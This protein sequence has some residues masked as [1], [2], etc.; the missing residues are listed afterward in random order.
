MAR[1]PNHHHHHHHVSSTTTSS[2]APK[3]LFDL[4]Q[5]AA[6]GYVG[7]GGSYVL[8]PASHNVRSAT[9]LLPPAAITPLRLTGRE[10]YTRVQLQRERVGD[11]YTGPIVGDRIPGFK[12]SAGM[13]IRCLFDFFACFDFLASLLQSNH[14]QSIPQWICYMQFAKTQADRVRPNKQLSSPRFEQISVS[15]PLP[16]RAQCRHHRACED[17]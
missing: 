7:F 6:D 2:A 8:P 5:L 16:H 14:N 13:F 4:S 17:Q 11:F 10:D 1:Q 9:Q 3:G 15:T 12:T